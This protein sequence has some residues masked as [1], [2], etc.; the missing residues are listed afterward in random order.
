M[1]VGISDGGRESIVRVTRGRSIRRGDADRAS[2]R[3]V[4]RGGVVPRAR[5][6]RH[7][8]GQRLAVGVEGGGRGHAVGHGGGLSPHPV[9]VANDG[10]GESRV[11]RL[12]QRH[13]ERGVLVR[14]IQRGRGIAGLGQAGESSKRI[15]RGGRHRVVRVGFGERQAERGIVR[16]LLASLSD[17][18]LLPLLQN[19][20]SFL[21]R[22]SDFYEAK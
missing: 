21:F 13:F 5:G 6:V 8:L 17:T 16:I 3:I 19:I 2:H 7:G 11:N 4:F 1:I 20:L 12:G 22:V 10:E 18:M 14:D 9:V 15:I